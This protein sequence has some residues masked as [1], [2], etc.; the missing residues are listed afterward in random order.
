MAATLGSKRVG[1]DFNP[2]GDILVRNVKTEIAALINLID[3][4]PN[5]NHQ[6]GRWKAM[7]QSDLE[8]GCMYAVKALTAGQDEELD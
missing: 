4:I 7:A 2:S 3:T 6:T 1:L 8:T 5:I